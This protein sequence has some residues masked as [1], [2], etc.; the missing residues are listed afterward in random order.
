MTSFDK[1]ILAGLAVIVLTATGA[2]RADHARLRS[3]RRH[4]LY[5]FNTPVASSSLAL[6]ASSA[7][8][9]RAM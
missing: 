5:P 9:V 7:A 8:A 2:A 1:S 4:R 6:A 3:R